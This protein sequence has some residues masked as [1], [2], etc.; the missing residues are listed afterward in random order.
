MV[1]EIYFAPDFH[2][3]F[4]IFNIC[5]SI[6]EAAI[7]HQLLF[8]PLIYNAARPDDNFIEYSLTRS[9]N[10]IMMQFLI[11]FVIFNICYSIFEAAIEHQLLFLPLI[12]NAAHLVD[13]FIEYWLT[14]SENWIMTHSLIHFEIFNTC[15]SIFE[16]A[17]E[18]QLLFLPWIYNVA[19]LDDTFIEY[20]LTKIEKWIVTIEWNK[21][22]LNS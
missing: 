13:T 6:F 4:V 17:I 21:K 1:I 9:E 14:R 11:Q 15:Y 18:H 19:R 3:Q 20:W 2:I 10:W 8:L 16:A 5:Y 12:Y 22:I 7:E